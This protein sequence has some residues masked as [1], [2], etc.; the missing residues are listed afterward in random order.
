[1]Y[2]SLIILHIFRT[3]KI[4]PGMTGSKNSPV[5]RWLCSNSTLNTLAS[6]NTQVGLRFKGKK[7]GYTCTHT[8]LRDSEFNNR[9]HKMS[10]LGH[11]F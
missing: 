9:I 10:P 5:R 2:P 1:M 4:T 6:K 8:S 7:V 3:I 11:R